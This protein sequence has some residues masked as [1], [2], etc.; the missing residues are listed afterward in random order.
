MKKIFKRTKS[1]FKLLKYNPRTLCIPLGIIACIY[2][3]SLIYVIPALMGY[4]N[5]EL[6]RWLRIIVEGTIMFAGFFFSLAFI[7]YIQSSL[8]NREVTIESLKSTV[9]E[10]FFDV[11]IMN[12]KYSVVI[13]ILTYAMYFELNF[14]LRW[15]KFSSVVHYPMIAA[16]AI[17]SIIAL[18]VANRLS[19]YVEMTVLKKNTG[20]YS[21]RE[22]YKATR[23]LWVELIPIGLIDLILVMSPKV[24]R[25]L[26]VFDYFTYEKTLLLVLLSL[27]FNLVWMYFSTVYKVSCYTTY[28]ASINEL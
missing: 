3:L 13:T 18:I 2:L 26:R 20:E 24:L 27:G 7:K 6:V 19:I 17:T 12:I 8:L 4:G 28:Q 22:V 23:E 25:S 21:V 5:N 15:Y 11:I 16:L 14:I 10:K 1:M 9:K